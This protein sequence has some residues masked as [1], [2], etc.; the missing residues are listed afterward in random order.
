MITLL[1]MSMSLVNQSSL[2]MPLSTFSMPSLTFPQYLSFPMK[3]QTCSRLSLW[4]TR[5]SKSL[6]VSYSSSLLKKRDIRPAQIRIRKMIKS[7]YNKSRMKTFGEEGIKTGNPMATL[8]NGPQVRSRTVY[9]IQ[10]V[11]RP[12][13]GLFHVRP[14][15][16]S[17][18]GAQH[19]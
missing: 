10:G 2:Q 11:D 19:H 18:G 6:P 3:R 13:L 1:P 16:W 17:A 4:T 8:P 7:N 9:Q 12:L 5:D 15:I 14:L